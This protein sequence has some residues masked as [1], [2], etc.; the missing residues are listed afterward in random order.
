MPDLN[1]VLSDT[2]LYNAW[3]KVNE[4]QGC[5]GIDGINLSDFSKNL[6]INLETLANE[7][8]YSSYLPKPLLRV[9]ID[10]N[11]GGLRAL[12]IPCICDRVLQTAV[13]MVLTP[14]FEA[15]F[16]DISFAYRKGRSV[17]Q[18]V[19]RIEQLRNQGYQWV[20][21]ADIKAFF[22]QV[23]HQ[24]LMQHVKKLVH[25]KDILRLIHLWLTMTVVDRKQRYRLKVGL[26]QGSPIS[27]MLANL[28]LDHLDEVLLDNKYKIIRY[29]DDF[30]ILCQSE[31]RAKQ[32]LQLSGEVLD[33]LKLCFNHSKTE[34]THF[35][36]GFRFLGV[37]FIR[38]L[39]FKSEYPENNCNFNV[40][41][42][43]SLPFSTASAPEKKSDQ[44]ISEMQQAFL[45]AGISP[46]QFVTRQA[47]S[48]I[49]LS[50]S[51]DPEILDTQSFEETELSSYDPRL[52]TLY[53]LKHG[54]VLG[55]ESE[56]FVIR[57]KGEIQQEIPAIHVD[58]IMIFGNIQITTQ[59]MQFSLKKRIPIFLLSGKGRY[60]GVVDSFDT[61]SVLLHQQQFLLATD[62]SFC[63]KL[64]IAIVR[65]KLANSRVVLRRFTRYHNTPELMQAAKQLSNI[66]NRL[67]NVND[68]DQLRGY[69]GSAARIYFQAFSAVLDPHWQF[70]NRNKQPPVDPVN[71]MLSYGYT[72]L[73]YNVYSFLRS[74][75]LNPHVGSLHPLRQGHPALVSDMMEE[76][77]SIIVDS[78]VFNIA[79]NNKLKPDD[80]TLP[81]QTGDACL[82][83][84]EARK[85]FI[86]QLE[87]KFNARLQHPVSG[88]KLDYRRCIE[89]QINHLVAVIRQSTP[90]Y[91]PMILR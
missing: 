18:A 5:A 35:N 78:V 3:L 37:D 39:V 67:K 6:W 22:D 80:F 64:S 53:L 31:K 69:E 61:E 50:E 85:F 77:R 72:L 83:S 73:F 84:V 76:F 56:R 79:I 58:Q 90:N 17:N 59:V 29:A 46:G 52:K 36:R 70:F 38:S 66:I 23:D 62:H 15:E 4:N 54:L 81:K 11:S 74:R 89:H 8:K 43:K 49:A 20:V 7:V 28:F 75:G 91:Q 42:K 16:E 55:K 24:L 82:L 10:K 57:L 87:N 32:A 34:I 25:N 19:S 51:A 40:S 1:E 9:D 41:T 48:S 88:L 30:V 26:P 27:P 33:Q 71:A 14:L 12:A 21:D 45:Q 65:G 86:S 68:L 44:F 60:Y 47:S 2:N 13:S 63:L